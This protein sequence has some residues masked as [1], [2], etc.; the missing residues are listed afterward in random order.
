MSLDN[1]IISENGWKAGDILEGSEYGSVSQIQLMYIGDDCIIAKEISRN[2]K[3]VEWS[4][5]TNWTLTCRE[6]KKVNQ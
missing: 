6:W 2:G 1:K 4:R 3:P 5:E